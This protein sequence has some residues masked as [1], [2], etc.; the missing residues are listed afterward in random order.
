MSHGIHLRTET[1]TNITVLIE[2]LDPMYNYA[3]MVYTVTA[4]RLTVVQ[5]ILAKG[6]V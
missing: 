1:L 3:R 2:K 5:N 6:E 4:G